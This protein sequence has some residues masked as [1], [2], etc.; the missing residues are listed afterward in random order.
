MLLA[1]GFAS[2]KRPVAANEWQD[3]QLVKTAVPIRAVL[4]AAGSRATAERRGE[5]GRCW[6][7]KRQ[8]ACASLLQ[9]GESL[10]EARERNRNADSRFLGLEDDE[11]GRLA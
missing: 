10:R 7:T 5:P 9:L 11:D 6:E 4:L 3:L 8:Q 2:V 1:G